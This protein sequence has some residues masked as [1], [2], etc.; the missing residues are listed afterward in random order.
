MLGPSL[1]GNFQEVRE[2]K[3]RGNVAF[4]RG[5]GAK[6][7]NKPAA[8]KSSRSLKKKGRQKKS[9]KADHG[10]AGEK[11]QDP[12]K[13]SKNVAVGGGSKKGV[14]ISPR[15]LSSQNVGKRR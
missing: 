3:S 8:G 10:N 5:E 7:K 4:S 11:Y 6:Q 14:R 2:K 12:K 15:H 13:G 9:R 1:L